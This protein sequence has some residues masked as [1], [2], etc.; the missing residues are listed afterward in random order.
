[1][2]L[3]D[4]M[5]RFNL[6]E[7]VARCGG[8]LLPPFNQFGDMLWPDKLLGGC[9]HCGHIFGVTVEW[10][11]VNPH[12]GCDCVAGVISPRCWRKGRYWPQGD[13]RF[14]CPVEPPTIPT[15]RQLEAL[16]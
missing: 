6:L 15:R 11:G 5:R 10:G 4:N 13:V 1:M 2:N 14:L 16:R 12:K 7:R 8:S 9:S 3:A